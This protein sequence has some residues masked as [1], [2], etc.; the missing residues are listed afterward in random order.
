[1][2]TRPKVSVTVVNAP[3][4]SNSP[5]RRT[6]WSAHAL[7]LP[8]DHATK[9]FGRLRTSCSRR[10]GADAVSIAV[11]VFLP[12]ASSTPLFAATRLPLC[13]VPIPTRHS[14]YPIASHAKPRLRAIF[15]RQLAP[16]KACVH[17]HRPEPP[18]TSRPAQRALRSTGSHSCA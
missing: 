7:S 17:R 16:P 11:R 6:S 12:P 8:L 1:M 15:V 2:L 3:T 9:A 14:L 13:V 5:T 10:D 18:P 4:I